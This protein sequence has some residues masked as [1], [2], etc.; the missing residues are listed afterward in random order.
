M[1]LLYYEVEVQYEDGSGV[2]IFQPPLLFVY[3]LIDFLFSLQDTW[4]AVSG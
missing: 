3:L 1:T 2:S 4:H